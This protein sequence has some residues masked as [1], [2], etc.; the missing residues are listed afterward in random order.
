MIESLYFQYGDFFHK[1]I[2][3]IMRKLSKITESIWS[4][5]QDRSAGDTHRK[6]DEYIIDAIKEFIKRH[7]IKEYE[8]HI[9]SDLS[10]NLN[11]NV[12]IK[13]DDLVDGK[14]PFKFNEVIGTMWLSDL[15]LETLENAPKIV[16]G[17]FVLYQ[18]KLKD[19]IGGP[20][21]VM[22]NF[23]ANFNNSLISL[24]GSP[25]KVGGDYSICF[26]GGLKDIKGI[27]PEIGGN[28]EITNNKIGNNFTDN[29]FR[30]Y[31]NIKG[32]IIRRK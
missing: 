17:C 4:D 15:G 23:T 5:M 14:L 3:G 21:V 10:V 19:F 2:K 7:K 24:D 25:K 1:Y 11:T 27:S 13:K 26:C 12:S 31:S 9:N 28:L 16:H 30:K 20:E 22:E 32:N 8:Y 29:D 18:N 6:E